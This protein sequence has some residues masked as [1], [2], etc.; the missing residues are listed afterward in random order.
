MDVNLRDWL[1]NR[2]LNEHISSPEEI[3]D[4]FEAVER[5]LNDCRTE[6]ISPDW[7]LTIAYTAALRAATAALAATGYRATREQHHYRVIQSLKFTIGANDDLI[8]ELDQFRK[9]RN[10]TRYEGIGAVSNYEAE[11]MIELAG[12]LRD[13]VL[14]WIR[15]T[16]PDL[17]VS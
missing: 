14:E 2:W 17:M 10:I 4:F 7:R 5:D 6:G 15:K 13:S 11:R 12:H 16:H 8:D 9:K 3:A 1:E